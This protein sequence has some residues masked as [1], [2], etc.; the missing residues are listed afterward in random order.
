VW[1]PNDR[2]RL[3]LPKFS[4]VM[5]RISLSVII[6]KPFEL[7]RQSYDNHHCIKRTVPI[8]FRLS[9]DWIELQLH[10]KLSPSW[11]LRSIPHWQVWALVLLPAQNFR[12]SPFLSFHQP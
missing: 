3:F 1:A 11:Q 9:C 12:D 6:P 5:G 4:C 10:T 2:L 7:I 8:S